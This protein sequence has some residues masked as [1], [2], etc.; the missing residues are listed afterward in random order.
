MITLN[1]R[2]VWM[3]K[4]SRLIY[5]PQTIFC[6]LKRTLSRTSFVW[7]KNYNYTAITV[8]FGL[9]NVNYFLWIIITYK[10]NPDS[11]QRYAAGVAQSYVPFSLCV[12]WLSEFLFAQIAIILALNYILLGVSVFGNRTSAFTLCPLL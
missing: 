1:P 2:R 8:F 7:K 6:I 9:F 4:S 10:Y 5:E 3:R 12:F 11:L